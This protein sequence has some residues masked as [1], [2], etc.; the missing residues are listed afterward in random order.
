MKTVQVYIQL[1]SDNTKL[2][3][4]NPEMPVEKIIQEACK[5]MVFSNSLDNKIEYKLLLARQVTYTSETT[6]ED[7]DVHPG[8]LVLLIPI[9]TASVKLKLIAHPRFNHTGW[10]LNQQEALIGR[11]DEAS[12]IFPDIDITPLASDPLS[13]SRQLAYLRENEDSWTVELHKEG[14][15]GLFVDKLK[16]E[17]GKVVKLS[18]QSI[19]AFGNSISKPEFKLQV[20]L[21]QDEKKAIL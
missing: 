18:D 20:R 3:V 7:M 2:L 6:F 13:I 10:V 11:R 15:S 17:P 19:L 5:T 4:L 14:R 9:Q 12:G 16:L 21:I 1:G 8:D